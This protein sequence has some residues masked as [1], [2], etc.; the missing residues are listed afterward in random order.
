LALSF[1]SRLERLAPGIE[2]F[3]VPVPAKITAAL[4]SRGP[5]PVMARVNGSK[6]FLVSL[7]PKGGGRHGLRVKAEVRRAV[8]IEEGSRVRVEL[9]VRDRAAET[10]PPADAAN[11]LRA[12]GL[13]DVFQAMPAGMRSFTLRK[14]EQAAKPETRAKRIREA[15][16][17]A[18]SRRA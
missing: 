9:T 16:A 4:G 2:Y 17:L 14:I 1:E 6:P 12:A 3:A 18:R 10:K 8:G 11:A 7:Y 15:V 5:V 13:L